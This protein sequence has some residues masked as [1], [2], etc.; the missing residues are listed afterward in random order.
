MKVTSDAEGN[1][2]QALPITL[3]LK[4]IARDVVDTDGVDLL[5]FGE[6]ALREPCLAG[7]W[8]DFQ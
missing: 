6:A 4:G 3:R 8:A 1:I 2:T 7:S 5:I